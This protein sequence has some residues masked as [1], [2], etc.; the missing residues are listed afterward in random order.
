MGPTLPLNSLAVIIESNEE[1]ADLYCEA[2]KQAGFSTRSICDAKEAL[3]AIDYLQPILVVLDLQIPRLG[4][5]VILDQ[6]RKNARMKETWV[7]ITTDDPAMAETLRGLEDFVLEKPISFEQ[8]RD[9]A[10]RL[11]R[12]RF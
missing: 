7:V 5:M 6:I 8:L 9:L 12:L 1:L 4:G 3:Q 2:V 10:R 11:R